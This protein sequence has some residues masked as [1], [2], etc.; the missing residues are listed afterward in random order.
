MKVKEKTKVI[1]LISA[2][3]IFSYSC[4]TS[5]LEYDQYKNYVHN[6]ITSNIMIIYDAIDENDNLIRNGLVD[7]EFTQNDM[8]E[9]FYNVNHISQS[10]SELD[11]IAKNIVSK[12]E[13]DTSRIEYNNEIERLIAKEI[14]DGYDEIEL[15][16][17]EEDKSIDISVENIELLEKIM[18]EN[19]ELKLQLDFSVDR[20][21]I[22]KDAKKYMINILKALIVKE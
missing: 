7:A 2:I 6:V 5:Y 11:R 9:L 14:F 4:F 10:Y 1:I 19:E 12:Y 17:G 21:S 13:S 22:E 15:K 3:I 18:I 20:N 16:Y 8:V